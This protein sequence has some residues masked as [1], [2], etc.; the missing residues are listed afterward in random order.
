MTGNYQS[1]VGHLGDV[2]IGGADH[3]I[4]TAAILVV[5]ERIN[6]I[7]PGIPGCQDVC[8]HKVGPYV[9]VR[10]AR[11]V[12]LQLDRPPGEPEG[13]GRGKHY[14]WAS[15]RRCRGKS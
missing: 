12:I 8:F 5:N 11:A 4:D 1:M 6:T 14:R 7:P 13:L 2:V 10:V 15:A 9:A 3:A